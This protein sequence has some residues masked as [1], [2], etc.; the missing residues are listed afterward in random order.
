MLCQRHP[1]D[2]NIWP[3]K[4]PSTEWCS[5]QNKVGCNFAVC[6]NTINSEDLI[7]NIFY[8][9]ASIDEDYKNIIQVVASGYK[10]G[11]MRRK[12]AKHHPAFPL[13]YLWDTLRIVKDDKNCSLFVE[14][15]VSPPK[16]DRVKIKTMEYLHLSHLGFANTFS[17]A[18]SRYFWEG[19]KMDL[20]KHIARC[21]PCIEF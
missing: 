9:A 11:E 12:V 20:E 8:A 3:F 17:L 7:L 10:R 1:T 6:Y 4:D 19:M 18:K 13:S 2:G 5:P 21:G 14:D 16:S 15:C